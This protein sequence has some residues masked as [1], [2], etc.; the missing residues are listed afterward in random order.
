[1]NFRWFLVLHIVPAKVCK[2]PALSHNDASVFARNFRAHIRVLRIHDLSTVASPT[3]VA[4]FGEAEALGSGRHALLERRELIARCLSLGVRFVEIR[5]QSPLHMGKGNLRDVAPNLTLFH[6]VLAGQPVPHGNVHRQAGRVSQVT[7][8]VR[9]IHRKLRGVD[10]IGY[11]EPRIWQ[12]GAP[13]SQDVGVAQG[14]AGERAL[15]L[16]VVSAAA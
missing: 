14:E 2:R 7:R 9:T 6:L 12:Q 13:C 4:P 10:A 5:D 8:P 1:M 3:L 15:Q 16:G 11:V